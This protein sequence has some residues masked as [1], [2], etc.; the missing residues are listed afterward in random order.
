[1]SY[2]GSNN[3]VVYLANKAGNGFTNSIW[4]AANGGPYGIITKNPD[5]HQIVNDFNG[6]GK[7]DYMYYYG[8]TNESYKG[9]MVALSNGDSFNT[10]T[11]WIS[12]DASPDIGVGMVKPDNL[13]HTGDMNGDG[14]SDIA[15]MYMYDADNELIASED[16]VI[17]LPFQKKKAMVFLH[18]SYGLPVV[19]YYTTRTFFNDYNGDGKTDIMWRQIDW[20]VSLN[21]TP[22][23]DQITKITSPT[24]AV[25]DIT[26]KPSSSYTNGYLPL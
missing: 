23:P 18:Q 11:R 1:L 13:I 2:D 3:I 4:L 20:Y 19:P 17:I 22:G 26:Y 9:W 5:K 12:Y 21:K 14:K 16:Q 8:G 15:L 10:P 24:G 6:D 7:N 25:T